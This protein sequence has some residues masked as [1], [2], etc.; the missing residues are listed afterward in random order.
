MP[1]DGRW[2][3]E[4]TGPRPAPSGGFAPRDGWVRVPTGDLKP[5]R[6]LGRVSACGRAIDLPTGEFW[7]KRLRADPGS[8]GRF[9][10]ARRR[11]PKGCARRRGTR[12]A[13]G[14]GGVRRGRSHRLP[15]FGGGA[16]RAPSKRR[17][18]GQEALS[19]PQHTRPTPSQTLPSG[20]RPGLRGRP[21]RLLPQGRSRTRWRGL[22]R[23][24][25]VVMVVGWGS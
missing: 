9:E 4:G 25:V 15:P 8:V 3:A 2:I 22:Q 6:L 7:S 10:P 12:R 23:G 14:R 5:K 13:G 21:R 19:P 16:P 11:S 20:I 24:G 18:A 17:E 1:G